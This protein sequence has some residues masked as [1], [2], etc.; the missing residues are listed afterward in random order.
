M[1]TSR[2]DTQNDSLL[3]DSYDQTSQSP[4]FAPTPG[5]EFCQTPSAMNSTSPENRLDDDF[6]T[7]NQS[8][9]LSQIAL[10]QLSNWEEGRLYDEH[11][12]TYLH[13]SIV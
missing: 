6:F 8:P 13:Y 4:L 2:F 10:L 7:Q 1:G 5:Y 9:Q 11:P 12:P 3:Y